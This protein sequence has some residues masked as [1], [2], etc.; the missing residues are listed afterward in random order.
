MPSNPINDEGDDAR[1]A[2]IISGEWPSPMLQSAFSEWYS[3]FSIKKS[4]ESTK[5]LEAYISDCIDE[6]DTSLMSHDQN[7]DIEDLIEHV[8]LQKQSDEKLRS[9]SELIEKRQH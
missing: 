3:H 8:E 5:N 9:I 6:S 2:K 7:S 4:Q 1:M